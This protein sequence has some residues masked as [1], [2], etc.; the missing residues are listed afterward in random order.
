LG[1][2]GDIVEARSTIEATVRELRSAVRRLSVAGIPTLS[3]EAWAVKLL[4]WAETEADFD[5]PRPS[6][7]P[8]PG[9]DTLSV[10]AQL[11]CDANAEYD[12]FRLQLDRPP[13]VPEPVGG[14]GV[15]PLFEPGRYTRT[16]RSSE[17]FFR[18]L[19]PAYQFLR[20]TEET[21]YPPRFR[22]LGLAAAQLG[23][24][25][26]WFVGPDPVRS[27]SLLCRLADKK[28]IDELLPRHL[29]AA[30][31]EAA[32]G[33][34][35]SAARSAIDR[36]LAASAGHTFRDSDPV[37]TR[38][39]GRLEGAIHLVARVA[40]RRPAADLSDLWSLA[41]ALYVHPT[42]R[43]SLTLHS[44]V[45]DLFHSLITASPS[46]LL[47]QQF[48]LVLKLPIPGAPDQP[49]PHPDQWREDKIVTRLARRV[50]A[51]RGTERAP[52][53]EVFIRNLLELA[54]TGRP[55]VNQKALLRLSVLH[56][57]GCLTPA[58]ATDLAGVY[59]APALP[60]PGVPV[61]SRLHR[62]ICLHM[63]EPPGIN[64]VERFREAAL[65]EGLPPLQPGGV[66]SDAVLRD[67][68]D[69]T[70]LEWRSPRPPGGR[71]VDWTAA[72]AIRM[73]AIIT[74]WWEAKGRARAERP[75]SDP[76][77][78]RAFLADGFEERIGLCI[79]VLRFVVVPRLSRRSS[80][81]RRLLAFV[82]D[83]DR[84]GCA[85]GAA[86]PS[87][88]LLAPD[89]D[90][91]ARLRRGLMSRH[92]GVRVSALLGILHWLG[93]PAVITSRRGGRR[94]PPMPGDLLVELGALCAGRRQPGLEETLEAVSAALAIDEPEPTNEFVQAI[95]I[96]LE[97]LSEEAEYRGT[98][99]PT[100]LV[101][102]ADVPAVRRRIAA[103]VGRLIRLGSDDRVVLEWR[104]NL[105]SDPLPEVRRALSMSE[106]GE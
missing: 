79:D 80:E 39:V 12:Y 93:H 43:D 65:A 62:W 16:F 48:D 49:V 23:A 31:P 103:V 86:L 46:D 32:I 101:P 15:R 94:P 81:A 36:G 64:A 98:P 87:L 33:D 47:A 42:V 29:V 3:R 38:A 13:P 104:A 74:D 96:G 84:L 53:T 8:G 1:E 61:W 24:L 34:L 102:D 90:A 4:G 60:G 85:V 82:E 25:A 76:P 6:S 70:N 57:C 78:F 21:A 18:T 95:V 51:P 71:F 66:G 50:V 88:L 17:E 27:R 63:P 28:L 59:W 92:Q 73:A 72:E 41:L 83:A 105:A 20:F 69:A 7:R 97:H 56:D 58:E 52:R 26:K 100:A 40:V 54:S 99:D 2:L 5:R 30:L 10:L 89:F 19:L 22:S 77:M 14:G 67:W 106:A 91:V 55:P 35:Y 68:L 75:P 37:R 11:G 45:D 9:G 44:A